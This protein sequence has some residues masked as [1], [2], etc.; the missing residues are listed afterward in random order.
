[1]LASV[2]IFEE[3]AQGLFGL[4]PLANLLRRAVSS[5]LY[6]FT[7]M[8]GEDWLWQKWGQLMHIASSQNAWGEVPRCTAVSFSSTM[9]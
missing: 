4:T 3:D 9:R 6:D 7:I 1:M 8:M 5:S 2:G